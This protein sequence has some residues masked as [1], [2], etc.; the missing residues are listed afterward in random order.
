MPADINSF[1][2]WY[3]L[4]WY[5]IKWHE[6][7]S[8]EMRWYQ[9]TWGDIKW[10]E[11]ISN[12]TRLYQ[13]TWDY[14]NCNRTI[15]Y[16]YYPQWLS[17]IP[18]PLEEGTKQLDKVLVEFPAVIVAAVDDKRS[19]FLSI[20]CSSPLQVERIYRCF[21]NTNEKTFTTSQTIVTLLPR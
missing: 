2:I 10:H 4:I 11:I 13:M 6:M 7:K 18:S 8:N 1:L 9:M 5:D 20:L 15:Y 19:R 12:D 3:Q 14:I 21:L 17:H 16:Y